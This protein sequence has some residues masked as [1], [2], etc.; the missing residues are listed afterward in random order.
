MP[1]I[2]RL[3]AVVLVACATVTSATVTSALAETKLKVATSFS[4]VADIVKQVGGDRVEVSTMVTSNTDMHS[5]Q[6]SP[7]D[8]KLLLNAQLVVINGLGLEY[9]ADRLVK[10]SGYRGARLVAAKGVKALPGRGHGRYDPH[11]WQDAA[12]VKI[13]AGNIRDALSALDPGRADEYRKRAA[14]YVKQLELLETEIATAFRDIPKPRRVVTSHDSFG[15]YGDAYGVEF[16]APQGVGEHAQLSAKVVTQLIRQIKRENVK[17]IFL[18][19]VGDRRFMDQIARETGAAI[20]GKLYS[21]SLS[22]AAGPAATYID[23]MRH[24]T[25]LLAAALRG[26]KL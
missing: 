4:I 26:Q 17:A 24:N 19:N 3:L 15:Y 8:T 21:D 14:D 9:W 2:T 1:T 5:F 10:A 11:A 20:G 13:Y 7:S 16:L 12:N 18:E 23:M 25:Q 22:E 6:P